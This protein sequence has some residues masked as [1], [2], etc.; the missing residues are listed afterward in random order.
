MFDAVIISGGNIEEDFALD[1][2]EKNKGALL[3][4]ADGGLRFYD[5]NNL[6][7]QLAVGDFDSVP[8]E[9]VQKFEQNGKT[10]VL[11]LCPQ[12]DDADTQSLLKIL[13]SRG[14]RKC[15]LLGGTGTRLDH[16]FANL[17]LLVYAKRQGCCLELYDSHNRAA[18]ISSGEV[19]RREQQFGKYVS[20]FPMGCEVTGLTLRGFRYPLTEHHL[21]ASDGGLTVSNEIQDKEARITFSSGTLLMIMSRD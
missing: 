8:E 4:A 10:E 19:L 18:V 17:E 15:A 1:F 21:L 9:L 14:V 11:R 6:T 13:V 2:L 7:P 12:K 3:A 16:V 5:R 20:F